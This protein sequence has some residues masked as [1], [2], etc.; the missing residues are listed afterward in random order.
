L[1]FVVD[2]SVTLTWCFEDE[3]LA[4]S[5]SVLDL[6]L[7][8]SALVPSIW[9]LEIVNALVAGER[10][11]RLTEAQ[12]ARFVQLLGELPIDVEALD[13]STAFGPVLATARAHGLSSY[14]ASYLELAARRGLPLASLDDRLVR[15]A[16]AAGVPLVGKT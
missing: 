7:E 3:V 8:S 10:R 16:V 9:P 5:E 2:A 13:L 12:T 1:N 11:G 15:A 14:D 6:F 4:Y